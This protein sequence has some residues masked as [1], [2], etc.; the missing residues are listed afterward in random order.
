MIHFF[1]HANIAF[2]TFKS[3]KMYFLFKM[4]FYLVT[5]IL[6]TV[7]PLNGITDNGI[8]QLMDQINPI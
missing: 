3:L 8:N 5:Q 7:A 2:Y 6:T 4:L 1:N